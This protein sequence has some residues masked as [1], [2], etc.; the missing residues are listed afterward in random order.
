MDDIIKKCEERLR[1]LEAEER[2]QQ[3]GAQRYEA[4]RARQERLSLEEQILLRERELQSASIR[5]LAATY[6]PEPHIEGDFDEWNVDAER[7]ITLQKRMLDRELEI[8]RIRAMLAQLSSSEH[9]NSDDEN[10]PALQQPVSS[11]AVVQA[12][13]AQVAP[14]QPQ[15]VPPQPMPT[16]QVNITQNFGPPLSSYYIPSEAGAIQLQPQTPVVQS[17]TETVSDG[18]VSNADSQRTERPAPQT[19]AERCAPQTEA[20]R[21]A[22]PKAETDDDAEEGVQY[23]ERLTISESYV[24][25]SPQQKKYFDGLRA[26]A[27][28]KSGAKDA[29][30]KY[31]LCV[32]K[33]QKVVI[34]LVIK[35]GVTV[36]RFRLE[37]ER[38]RRLRRSATADDVEVK[39]KESEVPVTDDTAYDVAKK[40]VNLRLMQI[41][42]DIILQKQRAAERRK[43]K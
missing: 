40:M 38:L 22:P 41:A 19:V 2:R 35:D 20:E 37:D 42:E 23:G 25:L 4:E 39:I 13:Q 34:K 30:A 26:Y 31:H 36:A 18:A 7:L 33:G 17:N 27:A 16:S 10:E 21:S 15:A 43:S 6:P 5:R 29:P 9:S 32:G 11:Q 8:E 1:A 3:I 14:Q 12:E 28:E 24:L